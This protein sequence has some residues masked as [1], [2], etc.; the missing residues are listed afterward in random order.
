MSKVI[1]Y[2]SKQ[3]AQIL[4][5]TNHPVVAT[6]DA[7]LSKL[8]NDRSICV[9]ETPSLMPILGQQDQHPWFMGSMG[10]AGLGEE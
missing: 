6:T 8:L 9:G 1:I 5:S 7:T 10:L 3:V 4:E 2:A